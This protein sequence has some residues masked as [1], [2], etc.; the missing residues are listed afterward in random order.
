MSC[1]KYKEEGYK[2]SQ[3]SNRQSEPK[4]CFVEMFSSLSP[5]QSCNFLS[6]LSWLQSYCAAQV[7]N[8]N[9]HQNTEPNFYG[10]KQNTVEY[11]V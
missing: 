9:G 3:H 1:F 7:I 8:S 10:P 6:T 2:L 4:C 5:D 11:K